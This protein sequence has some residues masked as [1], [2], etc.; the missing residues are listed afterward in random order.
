M[1][2]RDDALL[3]QRLAALPAEI[4]PQQGWGELR[5][6]IE[7]STPLPRTRRT[8]TWLAVAAG[9]AAVSLFASLW[10]RQQAPGDVATATPTNPVTTLVQRS[11]TLETEIR[12]LRANTPDV[13]EMRYAW[14]SAVESD[15][16]MVD[17]R[18]ANAA[19][20]PEDLW[21]E[22][23]RLLEELKAATAID[24]GSV[25]LQARVD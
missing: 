6:R 21:R 19:A 15:L 3:G 20:P 7:S 2:S 14:E 25:L 22:R 4:P 24:T 1:E 8:P 10:Q 12:G 17:A 23:V 5:A 9:V 18:L 13:D 11:Q 16:A